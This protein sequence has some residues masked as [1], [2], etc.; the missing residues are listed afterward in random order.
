RSG[1]ILHA[2]PARPGSGA[3]W[4]PAATAALVAAA[5]DAAGPDGAEVVDAGTGLPPDG[6]GGDTLLLV[7]PPTLCGARRAAAALAALRAR[8]DDG[9]CGLVVGG[10]PGRAEVSARALERLVGA[11]VAGSLPWSPREAGALAGGRWPEGR[12][13]RLA[14]AAGELAGWAP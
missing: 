13:A 9:G 2:A 1:T 7:C 4:R 11:P 14:R 10:A 3:A 6:S 8:R 12:R 5:R